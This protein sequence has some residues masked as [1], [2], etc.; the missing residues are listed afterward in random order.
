MNLLFN[1]GI[2]LLPGS[3]GAVLVDKHCMGGPVSEA[4]FPHL[5]DGHD[6]THFVDSYGGMDETVDIKPLA[7]GLEQKKPCNGGEKN[8]S[9]PVWIGSC[10]PAIK[11]KV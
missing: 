10:S 6:S 1:R 3:A 8:N 2:G 4:W 7:Q 11:L 5:Q 9:E